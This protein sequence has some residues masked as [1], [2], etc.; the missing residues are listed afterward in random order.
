[1]QSF[2]NYITEVAMARG[3]SSKAQAAEVKAFKLLGEKLSKKKDVK[4]QPIVSPAG[5]DA[6]FPDFAYRVTLNSGK[7]IDLH[8]E[9]KA[10]YLAQM[11]SMRDWSF[12]GSKFST[13]DTKSEAKQELIAVM[14]DTPKAIQ[15]GKRLL[16][17]LKKYFDPK[18]SRLYSGSLTVI[19]DKDTRKAMARE[20]AANTDNYQ[21]AA[22]KDSSMGDKII[23]H[24]KNKFK[25]NLKSGSRG[26]ILF[27]MLKDTVWMVDQEG[28]ITKSDLI[29]IS[30]MMG[31]ET[32][33]N[34]SGLSAK[35]EVRI[36]PRGLNS[37]KP[38][39]I[40]TMAS[41]RLVA[42]PRLGGKVN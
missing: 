41:F 7:V 19:S 13:P 5:F 40:D 18:V 27:M 33:H 4:V 38:A 21:I 9:Y 39:S 2:K 22:I 24:Y 25:K 11:G 15:N 35:L 1:M 31:L 28:S 10:D 36:Q 3:V 14:N 20:F 6:G 34:I 32:L 8:F 26:S 16:N 37:A 23:D 42:I 17:D 12:D 30:E 29:N